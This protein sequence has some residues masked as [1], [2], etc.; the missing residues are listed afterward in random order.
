MTVNENNLEEF[1]GKELKLLIIIVFKEL[2]EDVNMLQENKNK[3]LDEILE[4]ETWK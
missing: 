4:S 1:P 3:E 2:N